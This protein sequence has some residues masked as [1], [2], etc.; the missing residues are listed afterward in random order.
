MRY[1]LFSLF[2]VLIGLIT[3]SLGNLTTPA[4]PGWGDIHTK[5]AW[6][7][8]PM[9]WENLGP[10]PV[11][12]TIDLRI[13]LKSHNKDALID[14]L[15][16][17]SNPGHP[18]YG[19]HLSRDQ[20]STLELVHS[21]LEYQGSGNWLK[22]IGLPVS[23][24]DGLLG[25][26]FQLY[27]HIDT[28]DTILRTLSYALPEVLHAHV[29]TI[30]PTT[31]LGPPRTPRRTPRTHP[32][33]VTAA[34]AKPESKEPTRVSSIRNS[35]SDDD[36]DDDVSPSYM[37]WLYNT[38]GYVP[39]AADRNVLGIVGFN[40][41]YPSPQDLELFMEEFRTD[42]EDATFTVLQIN[43]GEFG[44]ESSLSI[45][46]ASAMAYPT[47]NTFYSVGGN[48]DDALMSWLHYMVDQEDVP[49]T[50][51]TTYG[52]DEV[53]VPPDYAASA[54]SLF[55][56]LS[57]RGVSVLYS[58][59]D[60]GVGEGDCLVG[61]SSGNRH[62]QF[63]PVFPAP[64]HPTIMGPWLTVVGGTT[65]YAPEIAASISSGGFSNVFQRPDYQNIAVPFYLHI[66]GDQYNGFYGAEGRGYP[67]IA[68]QAFHCGIVVDGEFMHIDG[69]SC[70]TP[71]VAGIIA[72]LNDYRL[73]KGKPVLGFLNYWLYGSGL[74]GLND[75]ITGSNPGCNTDGFPAIVGW[76]PVAGLSPEI[77][78]IPSL[79]ERLERLGEREVN[80]EVERECHVE[81]PPSVHPAKHI[82]HSDFH[83]FVRTGSLPMHS[84]Y[85]IPLF[86]QTGIDKA[87]D[88]TAES[89]ASPLATIDFTITTRCSDTVHLTDYLRPVN[90]VFTS[91]SGKN[92]IA[93]IVS[94]HE[95]NELLP[96]IRKSGKVRL[97]VY[98]PRVTASMRS[99]SDLAFYTIPS[100]PAREWTALAHLR[101]ELNL[102]AGQLYFD[103][104]EQYQRVC[105]LLALHM[106]H[107]GAEH[108]EVDGFVPPA[109]RTGKSSPFSISAI[110]MFKSLTGLRRKG[111]AFGGTDLGRVLDARPLSSDF[112]S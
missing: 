64:S 61:D 76:D 75:I 3:G 2:S 56:R 34:R 29:Q 85:I 97:H 39:K 35:G 8:V 25:A 45:Q 104:R 54:C 16:N 111:M 24:A 90:W 65:S 50:L 11:G 91:G 32:D 63:I 70:A 84:R 86:S 4:A 17:V 37:R 57:L 73:W 47:P 59:G 71:T 42:G 52:I 109:H 41:D 89:S 105:E 38:M 92:S 103:S 108:V 46:Y 100:A 83:N 6:K 62:V 31:Y 80:H 9:K 48:W 101:I 12:T 21:W 67:D 23:Q 10:P 19:S 93:I 98:A 28:S 99:F 33:G 66:L 82:I 87:L 96:T 77:N 40:G 30:T 26:S 14:A 72:V 49:Q 58:S 51:T 55:A 53:K 106:A 27:L 95:A 43:A 36:D 22:L 7:A 88:S 112:E 78:G 74:T 94:P 81:P 20:V 1:Y 44:I 13:A 5:H 18:K 107:P 68:A 60:D 102:F 110:S 69:T 15:Y 79:R